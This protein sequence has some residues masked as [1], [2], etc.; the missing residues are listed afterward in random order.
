MGMEEEG[1]QKTCTARSLL[2]MW[3]GRRIADAEERRGRYGEEGLVAVRNKVE[4]ES[5]GIE[6]LRGGCA[7]L[8]VASRKDVA[9]P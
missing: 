8:A 2:A 6:D 4:E 1:V 5:E 3:H 7:M 9:N